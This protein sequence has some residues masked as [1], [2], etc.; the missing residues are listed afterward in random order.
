MLFGCF[1][2][3]HFAQLKNTPKVGPDPNR[4]LGKV[5]T[6]DQSFV[7]I[8]YCSALCLLSLGA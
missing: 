6:S 1:V 3:I 5:L 4:V 8:V 7:C 2:G